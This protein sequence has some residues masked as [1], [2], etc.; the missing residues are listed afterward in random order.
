MTQKPYLFTDLDR[1]MIFSKRFLSSNQPL[2]PVE[3]KGK[4]IISYMTP[5]VL[6]LTQQH[7]K[8]IIPVTTRTLEEFKRVKPYQEAEWAIVGNGSI[9]L[10]HGQALSEWNTHITKQIAPI[11]NEYT[12]IIN[13]LNQNYPHYLNRL[14]TERDSFIFAKV[15]PEHKEQLKQVLCDKL[16]TLPQWHFVIQ[17][18]KVYIMPKVIS[19]ENAIQHLINLLKPQEIYFAGDGSLD[20]NMIN[21]SQTIPNAHSF[22]P[23]NTDAHQA[24]QTPHLTVVSNQPDGAEEILQHVFSRG[25]THA[26]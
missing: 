26:I 1:T 9:I 2:I 11:Q 13:W 19:K 8:N 12:Q 23:E 16:G 3:Y 6:K 10:H 14:A 25:S 22:T 17:K 4:T 15:R 5:Q 18:Q 20:I 21:L 24:A 7:I